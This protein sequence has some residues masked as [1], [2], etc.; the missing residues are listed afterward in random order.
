MYG[1]G[2][3]NTRQRTVAMV[4]ALL[5]SGTSLLALGDAVKAAIA[6][7][8][9]AAIPGYALSALARPRAARLEHVV[10]ALPCACALA[11]AVGFGAA[12]VGL[13]Y[14]LP[15]YGA[16]A[17]TAV[18][19]YLFK[20]RRGGRL[21][22][23]CR[24]PADRWWAVPMLVA[25][26]DGAVL[27]FNS[28]G[29][30]VPD[31]SDAASHTLWTAFI[32]Q[33]QKVTFALL[34]TPPGHGAF[35][36]PGFHAVA[37][38]LVDA[39]GLPAYRAVF[40]LA[41]AAVLILPFALYAYL[42]TLLG[43]AR[44]A[45]LAVAL[46]LVFEA[47]PLYSFVLG[48]YPFILSFLFVAGL[49]LAARDAVGL[50]HRGS[51]VLVAVLAVGLF[52]T[53]PTELLSAAL[54][55]A[56]ATVPLLRSR[57]QWGRAVVVSALLGAILVMGALPALHAI[58]TTMV[59]GAQPEIA[60]RHDFGSGSAVNVGGI[61]S[62]YFYY[63]YGRDIA[64]LL[65]AAVLAGIAWCVLRRRYLG[66][67]GMQIVL[68]AILLDVL[69]P[70][71]LHRFY[72]LSFPWALPERLAPTHYWVVP[73]L[74][75]LGLRA[76]ACTLARTGLARKRRLTLV[77]AGYS[78]ILG[79]VAPFVVAGLHTQAVVTAHHVVAAGDLEAMGWLKQHAP[80]A[81]M[82]NDEN[83]S[84]DT[85]SN[86]P[87]DAG[88]WTHVLGDS[89]PF[90]G[91][92]GD[93]PGALATRIDVLRQIGD[94]TLPPSTRRTLQKDH[95]RYVYYGAVVMPRTVRHLV[96]SRLLRAPYLHLVYS[97][98]PRTIPTPSSGAAYIFALTLPT[99]R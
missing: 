2:M 16:A 41:L 60:T 61:V 49:A 66:L 91:N 43:D 81:V 11:L 88:Y 67:V 52:Y 97:S 18:T 68:G 26:M 35:Y 22:A 40:L 89:T 50:G 3:S 13:P 34:S 31:A 63:I 70:N 15:V 38:L 48:V 53:H 5:T 98:A 28:R 55:G 17:L 4:M 84:A 76:L 80:G 57:R 64:W 96:L 94:K 62:S 20:E 85:E 92:G 79:V 25:L 10:L 24:A 21:S 7:L 93:G 99:G 12:A 47:M 56:V 83:F 9:L 78:L 75:A 58:G 19:L 45:A 86:M 46:S 72:V 36:P 27:A 77:V 30:S 37:A 51:I 14:G 69:G 23:L 65:C 82:V 42:R 8:L 73:A 54:I 29:S 74:A 1:L 6:L 39:A 44:L 33:G 90:F 95:V 59:S 71:L 32:A 87:I